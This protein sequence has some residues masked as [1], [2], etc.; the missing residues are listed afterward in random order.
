MY[1]PNNPKMPES[2]AVVIQAALDRALG[3]LNN[4]REA[5]ADA[6]GKDMHFDGASAAEVR[7]M[8]DEALV[9]A[10]VPMENLDM[11]MIQRPDPKQHNGDSTKEA[12]E[13]VPGIEVLITRKDTGELLGK[14]FFQTKEK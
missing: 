8:V 3:W 1:N 11:E 13:V 12:Q 5:Y 2:E 7:A 9:H 6:Y 10:Q 4:K 14:V